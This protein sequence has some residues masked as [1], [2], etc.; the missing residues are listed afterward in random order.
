MDIA[1]I[2]LGKM[3]GERREV[4]ASPMPRKFFRHTVVPAFVFSVTLAVAAAPAAG[5]LLIDDFTAGISA[6]WE[7]KVFRGETAYEPVVEEGRPR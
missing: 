4:R 5:P 7:K 2:G 3:G 6:K 1:M